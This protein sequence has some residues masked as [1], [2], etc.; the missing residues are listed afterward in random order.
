MASDDS[1]S[2]VSGNWSAAMELAGMPDVWAHLLDVHVPDTSGRCRGCTQGGTGIPAK[3]WPCG[4]R[5]LAEAAAHLHGGRR[6]AT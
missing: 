5:K 4:P 2:T 6:A 1:A 3:R